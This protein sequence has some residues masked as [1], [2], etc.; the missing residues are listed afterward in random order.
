[1]ISGDSEA[2]EAATTLLM[3]EDEADTAVLMRYVLEAKGFHVW[4]VTTGQAAKGVLDGGGPPDL[5]LLDI[6]LPDMSGL[7][8]LRMIRQTPRWDHVPVVVVTAS[9]E[10]GHKMRATTLGI[11]AYLTKPLSP[12][13]LPGRLR[14][15]LADEQQKRTETSR[16]IGPMQGTSC[17][18]TQ[19][20]E[21]KVG[22][23]DC[24]P[25][26]GEGEGEG[27]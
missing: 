3:V 23:Q 17:G 2:Q 9:H 16:A 15:L 1:M 14:R 10:A 20:G 4:P 12:T 26:R 22:R 6:T 27:E 18:I 19:G 5:V 25:N 8:F 7:E 24:Q 11:T 13:G 21:S